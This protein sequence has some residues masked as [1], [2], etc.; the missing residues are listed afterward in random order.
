MPLQREDALNEKS[1]VPTGG[2]RLRG[3]CLQK[4]PVRRAGVGLLIPNLL[5]PGIHEGIE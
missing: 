4:T 5:T 3:T 1:R 2:L